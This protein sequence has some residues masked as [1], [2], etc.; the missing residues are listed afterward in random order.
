MWSDALRAVTLFPGML[1]S[2]KVSGVCALLQ[3]YSVKCGRERRLALQCVC[4]CV[5]V[6]VCACLLEFIFILREGLAL[7]HTSTHSDETARGAWQAGLLNDIRSEFDAAKA[8]RRDGAGREI[9]ISS[10]RP[11][12]SSPSMRIDTNT[13]EIDCAIRRHSVISQCKKQMAITHTHWHPTAQMHMQ[14]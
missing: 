14:I 6:C 10:K 5:C 13:L 1:E 9:K 12:S 3:Y 7:T 8:V 11:I 2:V 4:V